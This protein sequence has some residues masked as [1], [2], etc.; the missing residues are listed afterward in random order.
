MFNFKMLMKCCCDSTSTNEEPIPEK[1]KIAKPELVNLRLNDIIQG[2]KP[3]PKPIEE[4]IL[5]APS[6]ILFNE[7]PQYP[8][9][10]LRIVESSSVPPNTVYSISPSGLENSRRGK[11]DFKTFIGS[12]WEDKGEIINDIAI[13]ESGQGM[14]NQ[15]LLIKFIQSASKYTITDLGDGSGTFVKIATE[16][17][18]KDGFIVS[19][20]N[21]HMKVVSI[22]SNDQKLIIK[23]LEGPKINEEYIFTAQDQMVI[24]GRMTD[25][26]IRFDD[27]NLSRY[28]CHFSFQEGRGWVLKDGI[29]N[30]GSTNGT[31]IYVEE[32]FE[33][34]DKMM[35]KAGKTLFEVNIEEYS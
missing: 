29:N 25:C 3:D 18:L 28:Q 12:T 31:W 16:L 2:V 5:A 35:F 11:Q 34:C 27:T 19:F 24:V 30:K 26:R 4:S 9:L 7:L 6:P 22:G 23:F 13:E 33:I 14:G 15:H 10:K 20:G 1:P 8:K 17:V 32:E 21:S